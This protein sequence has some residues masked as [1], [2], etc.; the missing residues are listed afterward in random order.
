MVGNILSLA[1]QAEEENRRLKEAIENAT[2]NFILN[3]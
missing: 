3:P 2:K 1:D